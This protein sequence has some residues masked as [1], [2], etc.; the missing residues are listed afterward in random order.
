VPCQRTP[1]GHR[2]F[3]REQL[4]PLLEGTGYEPPKDEPG[5]PS[6]QKWHRVFA[7]RGNLEEMRALGQRISGVLVQYIMRG[8]ADVRFRAEAREL[9][10][11]YAA[12]SKKAGA[13]LLDAT[14]AYLY[15]RASLAEIAA[16]SVGTETSSYMRNYV[17]YNEAVGEVLLGLVE[18]YEGDG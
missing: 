4:L 1:G 5:P 9:G 7:E 12:A 18:A 16:P 10:R 6:E 15:F 14:G 2:R 8:D 17:R 3:N 11:Q 13:S